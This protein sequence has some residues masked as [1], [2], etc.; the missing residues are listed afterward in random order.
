MPPE[1]VEALARTRSAR[2]PMG[3]TVTWYGTTSSTNDRAN[4]AAASGAPHGAV[5]VADTQSA[6]RGR[7]GRVWQSPAGAGL[8]CSVILDVPARVVPL[9]TL[10]AGVA[11]ADG[12]RESTGLTV[13]LKWPNDVW[14][15]GRKLGGILAEVSTA[16]AAGSRIVVGI[17]VNVASAALPPEVA[18]LAT[19]LEGELGRAVDRGAL[20][21]E[22]LVALE[23]RV[24]GLTAGRQADILQTW[25][26]LAAPLMGRRVEWD[27]E[28][29][30][31]EGR[32]SGLAED[33]A[34]VVETAAGEVQLRAGEVRWR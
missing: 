27:A 16:G 20:L 31:R 3:A 6:G 23:Q 32:A 34:L 12:I 7:L 8:Y 18:G 33:G 17:G 1:A 11:A 19:S 25:R 24:A 5:Y 28:G 4:E 15:D 2:G 13:Q 10:T 14:V 22:L 30:V 9:V 21:A 26:N 29:A